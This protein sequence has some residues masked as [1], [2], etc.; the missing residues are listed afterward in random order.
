MNPSFWLRG[1]RHKMRGSVWPEQ[2]ALAECRKRQKPLPSQSQRSAIPLYSIYPASLPACGESALPA[3]TLCAQLWHCTWDRLILIE[4]P[5]L[6][7]SPAPLNLWIAD[8]AKARRVMVLP[9]K[10]NS[11]NCTASEITTEALVWFSGDTTHLREAGAKHWHQ[12]K[13]IILPIIFCFCEYFLAAKAMWIQ[14]LSHCLLMLRLS[15]IEMQLYGGT[16]TLS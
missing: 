8:K 11:S 15:E 2:G 14:K 13:E 16:F 12:W 6:W 3:E 4:K 1:Q 9:H 5:F 10:S 7:N